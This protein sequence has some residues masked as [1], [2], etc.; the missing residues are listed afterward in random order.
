MITKEIAAQ[1]HNAYVEIEQGHKMIDEIKSALN[2]KGEWELKDN[3]GQTRGLELHIPTSMS[4]AKIKR[5]PFTLA[6][7]VINN[8]IETQK[9]E[10]ERLKEVCKIQ[11]A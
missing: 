4:G 2:E 10:L 1:I 5:V 7:D 6:L 3:W 11:L 9:N 8:H